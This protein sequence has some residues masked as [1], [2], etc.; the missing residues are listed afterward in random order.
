MQ[1]HLVPRNVTA[2][3]HGLFLWW[4]ICFSLVLKYADS[5]SLASKQQKALGR[6][7]GWKYTSF[8]TWNSYESNAPP[9]SSFMKL[10]HAP[11]NIPHMDLRRLQRK[12]EDARTSAATRRGHRCSALVHS[13]SISAFINTF[14]PLQLLQ[15]LFKVDLSRRDKGRIRNGDLFFLCVCDEKKKLQ[16]EVT[17]FHTSN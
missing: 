12:R 14:W 10:F 4:T 5:Y 13:C 15:R 9:P 6:S 2:R 11:R 1:D 17:R 8:Q 16:I 3:I 7:H